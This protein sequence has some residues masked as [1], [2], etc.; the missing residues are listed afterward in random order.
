ML[1]GHEEV[2]LLL[3]IVKEFTQGD[4]GGAAETLVAELLSDHL[5]DDQI[6]DL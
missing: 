3:T 4:N 5:T 6:K 2:A 1:T